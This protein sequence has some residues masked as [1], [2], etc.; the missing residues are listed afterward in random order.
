[1]CPST[2]LQQQC[3]VERRFQVSLGMVPPSA[4]CAML[5]PV[6]CAD[7][8]TGVMCLEASTAAGLYLA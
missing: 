8:R 6:Q 7:D 5:I 4:R 2:G 1:M 3:T